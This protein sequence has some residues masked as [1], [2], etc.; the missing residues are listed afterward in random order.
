M[1]AA[2]AHDPTRRPTSAE[3]AVLLALGVVLGT[4]STLCG[5]GGG[6][7]AVPLFHYVWKM[8]LPIAVANSLVLV[9]ASTTSATITELFH[10]R[11]S[12]DFPVVGVLIAT[13]FFGARLGFAAAKK[14][15]VRTLKI[16]FAVLLTVVALEVLVDTHFR[17]AAT[18]TGTAATLTAVQWTIVVIVGF[19]AGFVAPLLGIGGGLIAVPGLVYG[20]PALGYLGARACS[21]A[22]SMFTSWQSVFL[23][24]RDG[25]LR[26]HTSGW[27]AAG[28]LAGGVLGIQLVHI[29]AV[30][31]SARWLVGLA[32]L[33]AAARF[34]WDLRVV[35]S[36]PGK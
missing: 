30:T 18:V 14:M 35:A 12:L 33:F 10:P 9:L 5:I 3:K 36:S 13:S 26:T 27:L 29:Q 11:S 22:M 7:F 24:K 20:V 32:L 8:P 6:V 16:V 31:A 23:Y 19:S 2:V 21:M 15:N 25:S 17:D 1:S 4:Y 34:A 28:A